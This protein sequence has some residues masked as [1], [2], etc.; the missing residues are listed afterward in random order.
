MI[1][2]TPSKDDKLIDSVSQTIFRS[3]VLSIIYLVKIIR[4]DL[5]NK[6]RE[7]SKVMMKFTPFNDSL[8]P[9]TLKYIK[10]LFYGILYKIHRNNSNLN[11]NKP[12]W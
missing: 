2:K 1:I 10:T 4:H 3:D 8:L 9:R 5:S 11:S 12:L 7:L 6:S